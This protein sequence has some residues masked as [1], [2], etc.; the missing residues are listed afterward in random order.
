MNVRVF[1]LSFKTHAPM[2]VIL[3]E[4]YS[5]KLDCTGPSLLTL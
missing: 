2:T 5:L 3:V 1:D 4:L